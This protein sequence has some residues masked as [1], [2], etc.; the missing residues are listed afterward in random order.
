MTRVLPTRR[1]H[2][3][4]RVDGRVARRCDDRGSA[5]VIVL[6]LVGALVAVA[7]GG[8]LVGGALVAQRRAAAAAD[9]AALAAAESLG[10]LGGSAAGGTTACATAE[11]ISRQNDARLATCQV[12]GLEVAVEVDV[13][14][15]G[16]FGVERAVPGRARA[17]P[18][19]VADGLDPESAA[20][21]P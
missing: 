4:V 17:G 10:S 14:L 6:V 5:T 2:A 9:L 8:A 3:R 1:D 18:S 15:P 20:G 11:R 13:D 7:L 19:R 16:P 12:E 21:R